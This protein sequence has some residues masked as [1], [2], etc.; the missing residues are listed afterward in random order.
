MRITAALP[1]FW[2]PELTVAIFKASLDKAALKP[3]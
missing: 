1:S 2:K 3:L